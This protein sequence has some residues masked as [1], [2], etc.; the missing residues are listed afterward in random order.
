[1]MSSVQGVVEV[2][3]A[4]AEPD[5]WL[6]AVALA[7]VL[8][9]ACVSSVLEPEEVAEAAEAEPDFEPEAVVEAEPEWVPVEVAAVET[10]SWAPVL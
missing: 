4:E 9:P 7:A 8:E 1:M 6:V 5:V 2:A 10:V 3:V